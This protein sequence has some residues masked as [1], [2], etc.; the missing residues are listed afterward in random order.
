VV[1]K[2]NTVLDKMSVRWKK[3]TTELQ[4]FGGVGINA[5]LRYLSEKV[6]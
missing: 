3:I 2:Q 1:R 6:V 5:R 4:V